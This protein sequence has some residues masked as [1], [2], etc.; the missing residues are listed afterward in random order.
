MAMLAGWAS[1]SG[2]PGAATRKANGKG[3]EAVRIEGVESYHLRH[4]T[5]LTMGEQPPGGDG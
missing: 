5:D 3:L 2:A 1:G 4:V